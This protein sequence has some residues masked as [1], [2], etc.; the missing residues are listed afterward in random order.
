LSENIE[1]ISIVDRFLEHSR[2]Y[3]FRAAGQDKV[4]VGSADLMTRSVVRRIETLFP[5]DDP[6]IKQR[7]IGEILGISWA[8]NIKARELG[9]DGE[10][11]LRKPKTGAPAIRSQER[12]IQLAREEGL[13][14]IPYEKALRQA[15]KKKTA[16]RPIADRA[17]LKSKRLQRDKEENQD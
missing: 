17:I 16:G 6:G 10:Y 9:S 4:Y 1:V 5:I 7:L 12:F 8:D 11:T 13:K 2:I 3:Y 15:G 14:S